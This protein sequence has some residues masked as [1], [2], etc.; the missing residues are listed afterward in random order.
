MAAL[1]ELMK[2]YYASNFQLYLKTHTA[3]FNVTGMF[4][5]SLH[6]LL[7][8]QYSDMQEHIDTIG[9]K[10]R[11]MDHFVPTGFT[12][13]SDTGLLGEFDNSPMSAESYVEALYLD[14]E[15]MIALLNKV[16]KAA[17]TENN[18]AIANYISE[19]IDRHQKNRWM[20]RT[21]LN[22]VA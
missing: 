11:M 15:K 18:Q 10:I 13:I 19:R 17:E 20:L 16:F 5:Q 6:A 22:P 7:D 8:G 14:Q 9:E 4:F 21:S 1:V 3:H 2:I 12:W